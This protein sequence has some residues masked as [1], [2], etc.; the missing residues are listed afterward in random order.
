MLTETVSFFFYCDTFVNHSDLL[1]E[2]VNSVRVTPDTAG[3]ELN[4]DN[5]WM[6]RVIVIRM[7]DGLAAR[8]GRL[9]QS[10]PN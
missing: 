5:S 3:Q 1:S 9:H 6:M 4:S 7:Y 2:N 10:T 8:R